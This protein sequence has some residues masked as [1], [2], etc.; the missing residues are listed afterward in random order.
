M[1]NI[2]SQNTNATEFLCNTQS[3][4]IF[5]RSLHEIFFLKIGILSA[6]VYTKNVPNLEVW[7]F[8]PAL[9]KTLSIKQVIVVL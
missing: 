1:I 4:E 7:H 6:K 5:P 9:L 8:I 2:W 3:L